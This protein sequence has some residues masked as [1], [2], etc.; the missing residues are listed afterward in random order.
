M[1]AQIPPQIQAEWHP[2][3]VPFAEERFALYPVSLRSYNADMA[4][5]SGMTT[6]QIEE[7]LYRSYTR[8]DGLWFVLAEERYGFEVALA[9]DEAVWRVL[10][11]I[12]ARLLQ[13]QLGLGPDAAGLVR[14]LQAKL[15]LDRYEFSLNPVATQIELTLSRCPWHELLLRSGR[16][17]LAAR[18]GG[19][20]CGVELPA[21]AREFNCTCSGAPPHRLCGDGGN[22]VFRFRAE[23]K[24]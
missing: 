24:K 16:Q 9:L 13:Q 14:A 2:I 5:A 18:L 7:Y 23:P 11:K 10:P 19:V 1:L 17:H 6:E 12:Q 15:C 20:I 22:C 4:H 3:P 8:V 21:F